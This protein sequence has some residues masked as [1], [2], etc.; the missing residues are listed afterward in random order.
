MSTYSKLTFE[1]T[2]GNKMACIRF[3]DDEVRFNI[4]PF[5]MGH[6]S[7][8]IDSNGS[9]FVEFNQW[10]ATQPRPFH[11]TAMEI[12]KD[13]RKDIDEINNTEVLVN[14]LNKH[15]IRLYEMVDLQEINKWVRL[16]SSPVH[17]VS[18]PQSNYNRETTYVFEDYLQL[19]SYSL[20]LRFVAPIWADIDSRLRNEYG[21]DVKDVVSFDFILHGTTMRSDKTKGYVCEPEQRLREYINSTKLTIETDVVLCMGMTIEEYMDYLFANTVVRKISLGSVSNK[22]GNYRLIVNTYNSIVGK[23]KSLV[24]Q[25]ATPRLRAKQRPAENQRGDESSSQSVVDISIARNRILAVERVFMHRCINDHEH[26][27][28]IL[29]PDLPMDLYR[30]SMETI[31]K[32]NTD[33]SH[34][35][36][37]RQQMK[38]IQ[39]VQL[40]LA[41]WITERAVSSEIYKYLE[42]QEVINLMGLV[43]AI[44]WHRGFQEFAAIVSAVALP[45]HTE[46]VFVGL[47]NRSN[48]D[49]NIAQRLGEVFRLVGGDKSDKRKASFQA[50]IEYVEKSISEYNWLITLP[51]AWVQESTIVHKDKRLFLP[52]DLRNRVGELMIHVADDFK[53][54]KL[55]F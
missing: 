31:N 54:S 50:C 39:D 46:E 37:Y 23:T 5:N 9:P 43:R 36:D 34:L 49:P 20:A 2:P 19:V 32:M 40:V 7:E 25:K 51:D 44:L 22:D 42:L 8:K 55:D 16:P 52:R 26:M 11:V 47:S 33:Y 28:A 35:G 48:L 15:F 38:P 27:I 10:L 24:A 53:L 6:G 3:E 1:A 41:K 13:I 30:Q 18:K 45:M 29:Q 21:N 12:Y 4:Q 17:V 14:E